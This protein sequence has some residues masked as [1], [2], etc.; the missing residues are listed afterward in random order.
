[1]ALMRIKTAAARTFLFFLLTAIESLVTLNIVN[2]LM[3]YF[4]LTAIPICDGLFLYFLV[5]VI[6]LWFILQCL[7]NR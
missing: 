6:E 5:S 3:S 1:M 4:A 2:K 7:I